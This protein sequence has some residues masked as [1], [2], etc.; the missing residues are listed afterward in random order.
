MRTRYR[1]ATRHPLYPYLV[2]LLREAFKMT[3]N[4]QHPDLNMTELQRQQFVRNRKTTRFTN[5]K[6]DHSGSYIS[7]LIEF[8]L[9]YLL[10]VERPTLGFAK[11]GRDEPDFVHENCA[12][13]FELKV[14]C[15]RGNRVRGNAAQATARRPGC[16]LVWVNYDASSLE[17]DRV[18]IGW[19]EPADW[20]RYS[21]SQSSSL[22][23]EAQHAMIIIT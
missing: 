17:L 21:R 9:F 5:T 23:K 1:Q 19:V 7:Q 6:P 11:G 18:R 12:W 20:N 15:A 4:L 2:P 22:Q 13:N 16:W 14:S 3:R 10:E 8:Y